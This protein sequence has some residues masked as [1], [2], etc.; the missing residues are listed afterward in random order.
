[1]EASLHRIIRA[2]DSNNNGL[3]A[4]IRALSINLIVLNILLATANVLRV[5]AIVH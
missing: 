3:G 4:M 1:V 5:L 2:L